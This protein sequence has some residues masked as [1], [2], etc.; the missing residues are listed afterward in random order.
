MNRYQLGVLLSTLA[1]IGLLVF[2][3]T[4]SPRRRVSGDH[5]W[6][7]LVII[8]GVVAVIL[9][10]P[11]RSILYGIALVGR[12]SGHEAVTRKWIERVEP[13]IFWGSMYLAAG[14]I[15]SGLVWV[16]LRLIGGG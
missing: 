14:G 9:A 2:V 7:G 4:W 10:L 5:L 8:I 13:T 1:V 15:V 3:Y 12:I 6:V 11:L 16:V